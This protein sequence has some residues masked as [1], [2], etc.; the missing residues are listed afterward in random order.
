MRLFK[1]MRIIILLLILFSVGDTVVL[2]GWENDPCA[3]ASF[4]VPEGFVL[5]EGDILVPEISARGT[6]ASNLWP[7]GIV[8]YVWDPNVTSENQIAMLGAMREWEAVAN[9]NFIP[10]T[11]E[12]AY[13]HI[14]DSTVNTSAVGMVG[15]KQTL[16]IR[17]WNSKSTM[18][19]ELGHAL[20]LWHEQSRPDRDTYITVLEDNI[21]EGYEHNFNKQ[22]SAD[23]YGTYDFA[24]L[25]HYS[26]CTFSKCPACHGDPNDDCRTIDVNPPWNSEW[27]S[28]IGFGGRISTLDAGTMAHLYPGFGWIYVDRNFLGSPELG[29]EAN[30]YKTLTSGIFNANN[31]DTIMVH[32]GTYAE[33]NMFTKPVK[34]RAPLGGVVL[35]W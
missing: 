21:R 27:Q 25:M 18:M 5:I 30:P 29:T 26:Q 22:G 9:V 13:V 3:I 23:V 24:S 28:K 1:N 19:H 2:Y 11:S 7:G 14:E 33:T 34:L 6:Y 20:G 10:R 4:K 31:G 35:D 17:R 32:P 16:R 12:T 15:V 8:P